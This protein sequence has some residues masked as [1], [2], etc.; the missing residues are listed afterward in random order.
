MYARK[1]LASKMHCYLSQ[2]YNYNKFVTNNL[3]SQTN[4]IFFASEEKTSFNNTIIENKE[5]N[6]KDC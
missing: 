1:R 5:K 2:N 6:K 4:Y 3:F